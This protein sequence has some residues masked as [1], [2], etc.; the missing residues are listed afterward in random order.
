MR[1]EFHAAGDGVS[2]SVK[3]ERTAPETCFCDTCGREVGPEDL[4][5]VP[6]SERFSFYVCR[7]CYGALSSGLLKV[8]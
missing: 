5:Q 1:E 8:A 3:V 6:Q 7:T 2:L 4:A